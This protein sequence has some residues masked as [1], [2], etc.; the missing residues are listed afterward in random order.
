MN[1]FSAALAALCLGV[2]GL[3]G[4]AS[5]IV[6]GRDGGPLAGAMLMVLKGGGGVCTGV[7]LAPDIVLTAGHCIAGSAEIRVHWREANGEPALAQPAGSALHPGYRADA[8]ETRQRS[9]DLALLRLA[10]PLPGFATATLSSAQPRNG[11]GITAVGFGA[12]R[13]GD[14][15]SLGA[16]RSA[17]LSVVE[18]YGPGKILL[19]AADPAGQGKTAGAGA[20]QGDSGGALI[21]ASGH[22][23]AITSWS[24]GPGKSRCGLLTQGVL[25]GAQRQ[26]IDTTLARWG[27]QARWFTNN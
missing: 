25:V 2:V 6:G 24:T 7:V 17:A 4:T 21:D 1:R 12:G 26:W 16:L 15:R 13:D 11:E 23:A 8:I 22:V 3:A 20:C 9:V 10:E 19:W 5:A 27:R 18:P 14:A